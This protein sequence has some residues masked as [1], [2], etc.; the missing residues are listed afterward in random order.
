[1]S[2]TMTIENNVRKQKPA[3]FYFLMVVMAIFIGILIFCCIVTKQVHP[4]LLD[5][6]GKPTNSQPA[7]H[8]SSKGN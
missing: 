3:F 7:D 1:M 8:H 6:H 2:T 4:V 5:E